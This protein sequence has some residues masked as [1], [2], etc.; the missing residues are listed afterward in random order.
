M[1]LKKIYTKSELMVKLA[2]PNDRKFYRMLKRGD[3]ESIKDGRTAKYRIITTDTLLR[4]DTDVRHN[5]QLQ[6]ELEKVTGDNTQLQAELEKVTGDNTQLQAELD[7]V[8]EEMK[9]KNAQYGQLWL[10]YSEQTKDIKL[11][12]EGR[13]KSW[14]RFWK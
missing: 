14:W 7:R 9:D 12:T 13:K 3:F 2:I 6:A 5:T 1:S 8:W 4:T 10:A 11:L